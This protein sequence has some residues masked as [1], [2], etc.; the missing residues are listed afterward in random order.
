MPQSV[1][2]F[3]QKAVFNVY[4]FIRSWISQTM[5]QLGEKTAHSATHTQP[6]NRSATGQFQL[7]HNAC[8]L[9]LYPTLSV[10]IRHV[11]ISLN[12]YCCFFIILC[13][14]SMFFG[15]EGVLACQQCEMCVLTCI[16]WLNI[17]RDRLSRWNSTNVW[18]VSVCQ[19][20]ACNS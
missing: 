3:K 19:G 20:N 1:Y 8:F 4:R 10:I 5:L 17:C 16:L 18:L 7:V 11:M 6:T 15:H 2:H 14:L 9:S 12:I 13:I